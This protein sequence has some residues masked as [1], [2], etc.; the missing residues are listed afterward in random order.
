MCLE[1]ITLLAD[2]ATAFGALLTG[3]SLLLAAIQLYQSKIQARS[4]FEDEFVREYRRLVESLPV[5]ALLQGFDP[6]KVGMHAK[7]F[8]HY[9]DLCNEQAFM[10]EQDRVCQ[11]TWEFWKEGILANFHRPAFACAWWTH[12]EP[13]LRPEEFSE[14]RRLLEANMTQELQ[15]LRTQFLS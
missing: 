10:F 4:A 13:G 6:V 7:A 3:G 12:I 2:L 11:K 9:F 5:E 1:S 15:N 8:Y 14:L